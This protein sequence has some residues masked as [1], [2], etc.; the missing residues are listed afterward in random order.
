MKSLRVVIDEVTLYHPQYRPVFE[1][2]Y[3]G[4]VKIR[5]S[6]RVHSVKSS[7][8]RELF[9]GKFL[10]EVDEQARRV[11]NEKAAG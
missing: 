3:Q 2:L 10:D 7:A 8:M 1:R 9:I 4:L 5:T 6:P 11:I